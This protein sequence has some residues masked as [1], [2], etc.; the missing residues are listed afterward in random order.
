[1]PFDLFF[2]DAHKFLQGPV[3]DV[4]SKKSSELTYPILIIVLSFI[5]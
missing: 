3:E 5:I 4:P 1:M 2:N